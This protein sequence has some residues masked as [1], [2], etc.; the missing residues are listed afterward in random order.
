MS[1]KRNKG[2]FLKWNKDSEDGSIL[3]DKI[4]KNEID[5]TAPPKAI[6]ATLGWSARYAPSSFRGALHR[7]KL[8]ADAIR[9]EDPLAVAP[10]HTQGKY[11]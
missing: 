3:L 10:K 1:G 9:A 11:G 7:T 8:Q 6:L 2:N 5:L 4:L